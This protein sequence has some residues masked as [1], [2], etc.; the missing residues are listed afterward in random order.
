M[1]FT[2]NVQKGSNIHKNLYFTSEIGQFDGKNNNIRRHETSI[3]KNTVNTPTNIKRMTFLHS[4]NDEKPSN[5]SLPKTAATI[6]NKTEHTITSSNK[7][8]YQTEAL[9]QK[10]INIQPP[11][12][13][14]ISYDKKYLSKQLLS[15]VHL[16]RFLYKLLARMNEKLDKDENDE[17]QSLKEYMVGLIFEKLK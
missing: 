4:N 1:R 9:T 2:L 3:T 16:C 10:Q 13:E 8:I 7:H 12:K 17:L 14:Q 15:Q 5:F 6:S 11:V